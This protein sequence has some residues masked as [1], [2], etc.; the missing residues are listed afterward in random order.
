MNSVFPHVR[1]SGALL[2]VGYLL[3]PIPSQAWA[4]RTQTLELSQGW[5][6]IFLEVDPVNAAPGVVF[7]GVPVD[8]VTVFFPQTHP[9][10]YLRE[11]GDAPWREEGWGVWYAPERPDS[12][13]SSL[14]VIQGGRPY[15]VLAREAAV[16]EVTG[17]VLFRSIRWQP[18]SYNFTGLP[19]DPAAPP[20]FSAFFAG[21]KAH[22]GQR[23]Y[24]LIEGR[25][26]PVQGPAQ[27]RIRAGEAYWIYCDGVSDYQ[28]P[29]RVRLPSPDALR[30]VAV[31]SSLRIDFTGLV[32]EPIRV[33]LQAVAGSGLSLK[34]EVC[35]L[36]SF[37]RSYPPLPAT[38]GL[39]MVQ[40][41]ETRVLRLA[42]G[43]EANATGLLCVRTDCGVQFWIP[44][45][46]AGDL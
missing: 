30:F 15:L 7:G 9:A 39:G 3:V 13:L 42:A 23:I 5:N 25:W 33:E 35:D 1:Y 41:G 14:Q 26:T 28:G 29:L 46:V 8:I 44:V 6:A 36:K 18:N 4:L 10:P 31:G 16:L 22:R 43:G 20:T 38:L 40:P 37:R 34:Q 11:P 24:R 19:V 12:F 32:E 17:R 27:Q 45:I 21:S 2:L